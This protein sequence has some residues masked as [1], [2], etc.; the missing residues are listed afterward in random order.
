MSRKLYS[1]LALILL[2]ILP[3]AVEADECDTKCMPP[4]GK[5]KLKNSSVKIDANSGRVLENGKTHFPADTQIQLVIVNQ[6][7]YKYTYR[8]EI[9]EREI[10]TAVILD[11]L[12]RLNLFLGTVPPPPANA[13]AATPPPAAAADQAPAC[14]SMDGLFDTARASQAQLLAAAQAVEQAAGQQKKRV[15]DFDAFTQAVDTTPNAVESCKD[16]CAAGEAVLPKLDAFLKREDKK[17]LQDFKD[18]QLAVTKATDLLA[19]EVKIASA[20]LP[21][22]PERQSCAKRLNEYREEARSLL[23][24]AA[25]SQKTFEENVKKIDALEK[26]VKA[27]REVVKEVHDSDESFMY[28]TFLEARPEPTEFELTIFRTER[29]KKQEKKVT[30][31]IRAGRSRFSISAGIGLSFVE[32]QS[33]GR[34]QALV[35]TTTMDDGSVVTGT[36]LGEIFAVTQRSGESLVGVFQLNGLIKSWRG[37]SFGWALGAT[38]GEGEDKASNL[39]YFT[40]P[41]FAAIGDQLFFTLAYHQ[42][43]VSEL[44]GGF[45]AGD[46]IPEGFMGDLPLTTDG[47]GGLLFTV[48]YRFR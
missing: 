12:Q 20:S 48:T 25:A 36:E 8:Y 34:Q 35:P 11:A 18:A 9:E 21:T 39:G 26:D 5:E 42:R 43:E 46:P 33:F 4:T 40:G 19:A 24:L 3:M 32:Q 44:G 15:E 13:N 31:K 30:V 37:L 10:E 47:K 14:T 17:A 28:V 22:E 29:G 23:D 16:L 38:V 45:K 2:W 41:T 6:N 1:A 7:P 27:M